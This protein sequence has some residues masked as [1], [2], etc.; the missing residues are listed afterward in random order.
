MDTIQWGK[1]TC[2]RCQKEYIFNDG[3]WRLCTT[4]FCHGCLQAQLEQVRDDT[5][6]P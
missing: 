3:T 6:P 5:P 2:Q 4:E 1:Y